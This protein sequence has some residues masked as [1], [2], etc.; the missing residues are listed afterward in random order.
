MSR[1]R[2]ADE[3]LKK[4]NRGRSDSLG[5]RGRRNVKPTMQCDYSTVLYSMY[6]K[7]STIVQYNTGQHHSTGPYSASV[8]LYTA[9][10]AHDHLPS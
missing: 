8:R 2:H 9:G 7:Y 10:M 1:G 6:R 3:A 5:R 4:S